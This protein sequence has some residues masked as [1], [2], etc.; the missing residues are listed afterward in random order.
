M[1]KRGIRRALGAAAPALAALAV[2]APGATA[3]TQDLVVQSTTSVRDSGLLDQLIT[4]QFERRYPQVNLKFVAVG[5]G[6]AI[7]N[8]RAGQGDVLIGHSPPQEAQFLAD[9]FSYESIGRTVMWNDYVL[10][11]PAADPAGVL[12]AARNDAAGAFQAIAAA[13]AAGRAHFVSRGDNSGTN[14]KERDIWALTN[15]ARN[16]RNEPAAGTGNPGW[17]HKAGLGM[18]D[19]LRLTQQ[20]PFAGGGCYALTDRG[21][22]QQLITNRAITSL[23]VVMDDQADSARGGGALMLNVYNGYAISPSKYPATKLQAALAFLDFLTSDSFQTALA[24]FPSRARP[25]FFPAA[26]PKV[27]LA[28]RLPRRVSAARRLTVRGTVAS[29]VPEQAPLS[30]L[31]LRL[32]RFPTPATQVVTDRDAASASGAFRLRGRLTRSGLVYVT[33]PRYRNLSPLRLALGR[34]AVR[35]SITLASA[36]ATGVRVALRGRIHPAA[37]RR[38][39]VLQV[40]ARPVGGGAYE[41]VRHVRLP[42]RGSRYRLAVNL[43]P[44]TWQIKTR[45]LDP[46]RVARGDSSARSVS[47]G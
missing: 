46:G 22:L 47:A 4:P 24:S 44:G 15:V 14:V 42:S 13:G 17:Y 7:T 33:A 28:R 31:A 12:R 16:A 26:F 41:V 18:A 8:A 27:T 25:G 11:G 20:C 34:V 2:T 45:Y 40:R 10:V 36:R 21:T 1:S 6:Q 19:T 39:A 23:S 32:A 37:G 30:G 5:T 38:R 29:A 9:G 3:Q 35:A 43:S